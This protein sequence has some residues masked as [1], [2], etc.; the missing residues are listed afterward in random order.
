MGAGGAAFRLGNYL[1]FL[2]LEIGGYGYALW[3]ARGHW[4][5]GR[6]ATLL[7]VATL[8]LVPLGQ[9]GNSVDFTMRASIP[10]LAILAMMIAA[11]LNDPDA[12]LAKARK[13]ALVVFAIG[14]ATPMGEVARALAWPKSP[15]VVCSYMGVVPGGAPT[16]VAPLS[17]LPRF[18]RPQQQMLVEPHDPAH[19][20]AGRWPNAATGR[21]VDSHPGP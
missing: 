11:L 6:P 17:G 2:M 20:W 10:A 8:V 4:H 13:W 14:L 5:F 15:E 19:C 21:D 3:L 7:V 18:I 16:Y 9:V 1:T 12:E